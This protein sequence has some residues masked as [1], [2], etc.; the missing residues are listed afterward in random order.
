MDDLTDEELPGYALLHC[1]TE[2]GAF[3]KKHIARLLR[4]A[5]REEEA[6]NVDNGRDWYYLGPNAIRPL[7]DSVTEYQKQ[8]KEKTNG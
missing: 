2:I 6:V 8:Q 4:M 7:V 1:E 5:G 3:H